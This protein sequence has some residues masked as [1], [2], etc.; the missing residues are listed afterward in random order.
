MHAFNID[1]TAAILIAHQVGTNTWA[2]RT[3]LALLQANVIILAKFATG[4]GMPLVLT[5]GQETNVD[6]QGPLMPEL[7]E[8]AP[9]AFAARIQ[10][11]GVVNARAD[12]DFAAASRASGRRNFTMAGVTTNVCM[13]VPGISAV[14]E[15]FIVQMVCDACGYSNPI[16]KVVVAAHGGCGR[17]ID[18][19]QHHRRRVGQEQGKPSRWGCIPVARAAATSSTQAHTRPATRSVSA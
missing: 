3:P 13:V 12:E 19:H 8:I 18:R 5:C 15:S 6:V 4:T 16:A 14:Q 11:K 9:Q 10:R 17:A 7:A 2:A 1:D